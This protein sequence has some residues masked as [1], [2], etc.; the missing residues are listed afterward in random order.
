M[1]LHFTHPELTEKLPTLTC[2]L[3]GRGPNICHNAV[4]PHQRRGALGTQAGRQ[5][6][7]QTETER[8]REAA[9]SDRQTDRQRHE[10]EKDGD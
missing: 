3:P 4:C 9:E 5:T 7:R 1:S 6:D 2:K 10:K 8:K